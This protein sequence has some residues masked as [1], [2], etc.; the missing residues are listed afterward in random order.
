MNIIKIDKNIPNIIKMPKGH[1][2]YSSG[3]QHV[4][5]PCN[6]CSMQFA[7]KLAMKLHLKTS[8]QIDTMPKNTEF[9]RPYDHP[10]INQERYMGG[11]KKGQ[12][13]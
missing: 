9:H 8:H 6:Y 13:E 1:K 2:L 5:I 4:E 3:G 12:T 11:H 10:N 7:N